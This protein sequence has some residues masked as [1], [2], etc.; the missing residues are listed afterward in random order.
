[1]APTK[2]TERLNKS[3]IPLKCRELHSLSSRSK[4]PLKALPVVPKCTP[5]QIT[6][7]QLRLATILAEFPL[8]DYRPALPVPDI[9]GEPILGQMSELAT[10]ESFFTSECIEILVTNTNSYVQ[11]TREYLGSLLIP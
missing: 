9:K 8:P 11:Y 5:R 1:M 3:Q 10:F 7:D 6:K 2:I 4:I